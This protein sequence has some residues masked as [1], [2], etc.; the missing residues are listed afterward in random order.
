[1]AQEFV[2][3]TYVEKDGEEVIFEEAT[4][5]KHWSA[6]QSVRAAVE[7]G[8][9]ITYKLDAQ[10]F[11]VTTVTLQF[12]PEDDTFDWIIEHGDKITSGG[13]RE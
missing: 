5:D 1:M 6:S 10:G 11:V 8:T 13:N 2:Y 12:N 4:Y 9:S 3:G 7:A